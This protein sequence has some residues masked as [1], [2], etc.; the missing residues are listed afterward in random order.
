MSGCVWLFL[1]VSGCVS[2]CQFVSACI[3]LCQ[4]VSA[5]LVM[6][7]CVWLCP[8]CVQIVSLLSRGHSLK[9]IFSLVC[10]KNWEEREEKS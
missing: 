1:V 3:S 5:C 2:L 9:A 4:L 6:S 10:S 7:D 8:D